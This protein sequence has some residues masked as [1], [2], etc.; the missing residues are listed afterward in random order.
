MQLRNRTCLYTPLSV[1]PGVEPGQHECRPGRTLVFRG[2]VPDR[3]HHEGGHQ[4]PALHP[5]R[6]QRESAQRDGP[7]DP[8]AHAADGG[9]LAPAEH[10]AGHDAVRL[11]HH[12]VEAPAG[13]AGEGKLQLHGQGEPDYIHSADEDA[14]SRAYYNGQ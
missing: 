12:P 9:H 10:A 3:G 5:Q 7:E 14:L 11:H 8:A 6:P 1:I 13:R 2:R 4:H